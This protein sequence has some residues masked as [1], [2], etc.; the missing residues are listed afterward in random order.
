ML[1]WNHCL[2]TLLHTLSNLE[3]YFKTIP[4]QCRKPTHCLRVPV[5]KDVRNEVCK[6]QHEKCHN[7]TEPDSGTGTRLYNAEKYRYR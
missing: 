1:V 3:L 2:R 6:L 7:T 4:V 5:L